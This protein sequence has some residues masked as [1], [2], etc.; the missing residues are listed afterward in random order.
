LVSTVGTFHGSF[1]TFTK[2]I[3]DTELVCI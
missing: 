3:S 1:G 2:S